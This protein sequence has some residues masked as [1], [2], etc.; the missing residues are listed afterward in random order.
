[1]T[2]ATETLPFD[3]A[4]RPLSG[5]SLWRRSLTRLLRNPMGVTGLIIVLV[6]VVLG[7]AA[8]VIAPRDP[9]EQFRGH[10][11]ESPSI[12]FWFGTDIFSRDLFSRTLHGLRA[13]ILISIFA[14]GVGGAVGTAA[15]FLAGYA[16]GIVETAIMRFVDVLLAFP[17]LLLALTLVATLGSTQVNVALALGIAAMPVFVRLSRGQ[18]LVEAQQ[19]YVL[20]ARAS[21][22]TASRI[23]LRHIAMN[24]VP[25]LLV[26]GALSM[27]T[28]VLLE[29]ALGF[30]GIGTTPPDPSLG[31]LINDA[32]S[33][34]D[35][36]HLLVFPASFLALFLFGLN[37]LADA[38]NDTLDPYRSRNTGS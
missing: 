5:Q 26:Q 8:P 9:L 37:I 7:L 10:R 24:A 6:L 2:D 17:S 13:S 31:Q 25:P 35:E 34:L 1:V 23:V 38:V 22:A 30:L 11:L 32:R 18:M 16:R 21:G 12:E 3:L 20:A 15:G 4:E 19:D 28:A 27:A 29:A 33:R 14:V 36:W